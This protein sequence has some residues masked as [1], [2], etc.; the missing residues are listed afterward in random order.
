MGRA[1]QTDWSV[2]ESFNSSSTFRSLTRILIFFPIFHPSCFKRIELIKKTFVLLLALH[3][4]REEKNLP[5]H[6]DDLTLQREKFLSLVSQQ[7]ET[8]GYQ[9]VAGDFS[10][11]GI[12]KMGLQTI[13]VVVFDE[14]PYRVDQKAKRDQ[15]Q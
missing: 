4:V 2:L 9:N 8:Q 14:K 1:S 13:K 6:L 12:Q 3:V 11:K 15:L 7:K 5:I 10:R